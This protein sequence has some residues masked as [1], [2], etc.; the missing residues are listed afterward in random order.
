METKRINRAALFL[1]DFAAGK[2][3][4]GAHTFFT[5]PAITEALA[6]Y[7]FDYIWI[8]G[9][10]S[11][12]S[13]ETLFSHILAAYS[14]GAA[15]FVRV[16][17]NDP[18]LLK[19]ILEMNPDAIIIPLVNTVD[20]A[21]KA[22]A[23]C[24]YPPKG[25]RGFGPRR[26]NNYGDMDISRYFEEVEKTFLTIIQIENIK[27]VENIEAI[28]AVEGIDGIILGP[29]DLTISMGITGQLKHEKF[30]TAC[31][32]VFNVSKAQNKPCGIAIGCNDMD[33]FKSWINKGLFLVSCGDDLGYLH[34]GAKR[35]L[36][37]AKDAL[38]S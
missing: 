20:D 27:A 15:S 16:P 29:M 11:P 17:W 4:I 10:H 18:V 38:N 31:D 12:F 7:G 2:T 9:E 37:N 19:P 3:K 14:G 26:A 5:D 24:R 21:L 36:D 33:Y 34:F 22:S 35:V 6:L 1:K 28:I 13:N 30:L 23:A 25:I 32:K 8:D